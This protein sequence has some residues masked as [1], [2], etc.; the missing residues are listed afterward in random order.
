[1]L[2]VPELLMHVAGTAITE[3][4]GI[5]GDATAYVDLVVEADQVGKIE[6]KNVFFNP[7][8][9]EAAAIDD[10]RR[11]IGI[12][13]SNKF[14][15][16]DVKSVHM[17][18][19]I[20]SGRKTASIERIFIDKSRYEPGEMVNVGIELRPYKSQPF[21]KTMQIQ[22]P[23]N[24]P[25]GK[26]TLRV[27][28]GMV[29]GGEAP[30]MIS[31][32]PDGDGAAIT[33]MPGG[34]A[35]NI[36]QMISKFVEQEKNN[37]LI[38]RLLLPTGA[39]SISGEKL[40]N[41]PD[42]IAN[43]I[44]SPRSTGL[45]MERDEVKVVE[46]VDYILTGAQSLP[47]TV[48]R[49]RKLEKRQQQGDKSGQEA[50]RPMPEPMVEAEAA[51]LV[52]DTA[53][54][55]ASVP[56][57]FF[58]D[59]SFVQMTRIPTPAPEGA[60]PSEAKPAEQAKQEQKPEEKKA[61]EKKEAEKP[62]IRQ[63]NIW[64]Q[65]SLQ[66]FGP[67]SFSSTAA[68]D[69]DDVRL[70][71]AFTKLSDVP[72]EI[73]WTVLPIGGG[74]ALVGTG[75]NGIVYRVTREGACSSF[76][77]TGELEVHSLVQDSKGNIYAGTS[78]NGKVYKISPDGQGELV[79]DAPEKYV[80]ALTV[81]SSDNV[82]AG[83]GDAG[84]IYR[85]TSTG[86]STTFV[87]LPNPSVMALTVDGAGNVYAGTGKGGVIFKISPAGAITPLYNAPEDS[88]TSVA[89]DKNGNVFAG[90]GVGKGNIYEIPVSGVPKPILDR[91]PRALSMAIDRENNVYV[92][93][94]EQIFKILPDDTA[95]VLDTDRAA[96]QFTAIAISQDGT[97]LA[98]AANR[99][100]LFIAP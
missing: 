6:R 44:K 68:T 17:S 1:P 36:N 76:F 73:V 67:G 3:V 45:K 2:L 90:T 47:I 84:K 4:H 93:S 23:E 32:N 80:L 30:V 8:S 58:D 99:G 20:E 63:P 24:A 62:V 16:L 11:I 26:L 40:T 38:V 42:P 28:G 91:A 35:D 5:P 33:P 79:F 18:V 21:I 85:I 81:D 39:I 19:Q 70:A 46:Q 100:A 96:V 51:L 56:F 71:P 72:E 77:S 94:D 27:A 15:P 74:D 34:I 69:A 13:T 7:A 92:V 57:G 14:Q 75:N 83:V 25:D 41:L 59:A 95:M 37:E 86:E 88:I 31:P 89:V 87:E 12:L 50:S 48:A 9:I 65:K 29:G 54:I 53:D 82:Y 66:D 61:D 49:Q 64:T 43:V 10:L 52:D 97:L 55:A 22:V 98:G 60:G 78:P